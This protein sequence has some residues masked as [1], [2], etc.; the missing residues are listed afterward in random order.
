MKWSCYLISPVYDPISRVHSLP[1]QSD[2]VIAVIARET[3]APERHRI[4]LVSGFWRLRGKGGCVLVREVLVRFVSAFEFAC[5]R[6]DFFLFFN[7][8][9]FCLMYLWKYGFAIWMVWFRKGNMD[10]Y[11]HSSVLGLWEI[12]YQIKR[13]YWLYSNA[14]DY[15][16]W[17]NEGKLMKKRIILF[18][19]VQLIQNTHWLKSQRGILGWKKYLLLF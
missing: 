19:I 10:F 1:Y 7:V 8:G 18:I 3:E 5:E 11:H 6:S 17:I 13:R 9:L 12:C 14:T 16:K 2:N 15:T 4:V